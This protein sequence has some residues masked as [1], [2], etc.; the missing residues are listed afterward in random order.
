[1]RTEGGL[2]LHT[3]VFHKQSV[4]EVN[5]EERVT[6][7]PKTSPTKEAPANVGVAIDHAELAEQKI[8]LYKAVKKK[9]PKSA[10]DFTTGDKIKK[11]V[12]TKIFPAETTVPVMKTVGDQPLSKCLEATYVV[13]E[14][15]IHKSGWKTVRL[16]GK[17]T[18]VSWREGVLGSKYHISI[19]I[20]CPL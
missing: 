9:W 20:V 8:A 14:I 13:E 19:P 12:L 3:Q 11:S 7:K 5:K 10:T 16:R 17:R 1:M 2:K 18:L 6:A 15:T 4:A